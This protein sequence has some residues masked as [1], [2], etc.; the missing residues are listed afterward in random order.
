MSE[1][2][3]EANIAIHTTVVVI[4]TKH[5]SFTTIVV[6]ATTFEPRI[7]RVDKPRLFLQPNPYANYNSLIC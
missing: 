5:T 7:V 1:N 4:E 3:T 6:S 2:E